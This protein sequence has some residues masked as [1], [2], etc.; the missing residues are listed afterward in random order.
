ML[1][2]LAWGALGAYL[3]WK[4]GKKLS[5]VGLDRRRLGSDALRG[6]GLAALIGLP[7]IAFYLITRAMGLNLTVVPS[8]LDDTW[9]RTPALILSAIGNSWAEEVLVV[10][11]LITRLR[12]LGWSENR[13]LAVSA[14]LRGSYHLYQGFGGFAGNIVMGL[15]YGRVWQRTNR[16]TALVVGHAVI[17]IVAFVGYALLR[18]SV[19]WLP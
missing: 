14:V 10:G 18:G 2:L 6:L 8:A 4:A 16:L 11:Y 9:W 12:M 5:E 7:G 15:V 1:Q 3:L 17:D 13:S 19:S